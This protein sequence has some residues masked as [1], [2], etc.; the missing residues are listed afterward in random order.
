LNLGRRAFPTGNSGSG[1]RA[2]A[3]PG[4]PRTYVDL[5][6]SRDDLSGIMDAIRAGRLFFT[7][8][9]IV[10]FR[11]AGGRPAGDLVQD[12]DGLVDIELRIEAATWVDV[13]RVRIFVNGSALL[14]R[15]LPGR[16]GPRVADLRE[17]LAINGDSW[18]VAVASGSKPL[19][20]IY[21]GSKGE[22][23]FPVAVTSPIWVDFDGDGVFDPPGIP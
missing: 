16:K 11:A 13:D 8:G 22:P 18:L 23:I 12:S 15:S 6:D 1:D 5:F 19:D 4:L 14:D 10:R 7:T 2:L 21:R 9:P 17:S 20:P 3:P